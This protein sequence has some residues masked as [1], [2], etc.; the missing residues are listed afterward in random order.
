[1]SKIL[2]VFVLIVAILSVD[3]LMNWVQQQLAVNGSIR[4]NLFLAPI[5]MMGVVLIVLYPLITHIEKWSASFSK[6][7]FKM[8]KKLAGRKFGIFL[9][10]FLAMAI[11]YYLYAKFWF[12]IDMIRMVRRFFHF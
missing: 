11:L 10:F 2:K 5:I 8:G 6:Q 9:S 3:L 12:H 4:G 7:F 1:M